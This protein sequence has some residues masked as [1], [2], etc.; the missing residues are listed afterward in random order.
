[1]R[2]IEEESL[3]K[4]VNI[5]ATVTLPHPLDL[6]KL[7][8]ELP[9]IDTSSKVSWLKMRVQPEGYYVAF[10][11]SGKFLVMGKSLEQL[12]NT[13]NKVIALL[14]SVG[15]TTNPWQLKVH[16]MVLTDN[17]EMKMSIEH[18]IYSL[19]PKKASYEPEQ[20]PALV[21]KDWGVSFLLFNSGKIV[22][23][24]VKNEN[25]ARELMDKFRNL[26]H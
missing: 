9:G 1:M 21:Y 18:L 17:I 11:K 19:D 3:M 4:T 8:N 6:L 22:L 26:T 12:N 5:V 23:T 13:A 14:N 16:N 20:F 24:G 25:D 7:R 2:I 15:I 10:Y